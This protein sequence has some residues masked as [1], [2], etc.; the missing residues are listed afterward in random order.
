MVD[1]RLTVGKVG[2]AFSETVPQGQVISTAPAAN[3]S[4]KRASPVNL[5]VSA[6]RQPIAVTDWTGRPASQAT[7]AMT[8][9]KLK[10]TATKQDWSDTVPKGS[11]ISQSPTSGTLFQGS[12]VTLVVS[13]GPVLVTVPN[14]VS[15]QE[16]PAR[17]VLEGLGFKVKVERAFG[18]FFRT[19][20][21]QSIA[22]GSQAPRGST[23]TLTVV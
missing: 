21:L 17:S 22:A 3:T 9:A 18:G 14:V 8:K 4:L 10:V 5:V 16:G 15:Q 1:A 2:K 11:V 6:G 12:L 13:K 19:V 23:I 7:A 20:R